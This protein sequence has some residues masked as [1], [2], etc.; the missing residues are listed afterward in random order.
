[1]CQSVSSQ[2]MLLL[3]PILDICICSYVFENEGVQNNTN[4]SAFHFIVRNSSI[5]GRNFE[6]VD[7][8]YMVEI[9]KNSK[10]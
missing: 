8:C 3:D 6:R 2:N 1:M 5:K 9:K 4:E 7:A 10:V